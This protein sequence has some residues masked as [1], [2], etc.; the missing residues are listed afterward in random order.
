MKLNKGISLQ[1]NYFDLANLEISLNIFF[2]NIGAKEHKFL[3]VGFNGIEIEIRAERKVLCSVD[4]FF[5]T[6][7]IALKTQT[8]VPWWLSQLPVICWARAIYCIS[9]GWLEN[10]SQ[11]GSKVLILVSISFVLL[12]PADFSLDRWKPDI[13]YDCHVLVL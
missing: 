12:V 1:L 2:C 5:N 4:Y 10:V 3:P 8:S 9:Y 11:A 7:F 6:Y 13:W